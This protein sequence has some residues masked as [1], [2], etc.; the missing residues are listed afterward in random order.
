[1]L[2]F[3]RALIFGSLL[4]LWFIISYIIF[5]V[6]GVG[7]ISIDPKKPAEDV[8]ASLADDTSSNFAK[9]LSRIWSVSPSI[10]GTID[11]VERGSDGRLRLAGWAID[12]TKA[13][14]LS[15]FLIIP[16]KAVLLTHTG[17]KRDDVS[18]AL[19]LSKDFDLAGFDNVFPFE[20]DCKD[21]DLNP[22]IVAVNQTKEFSLIT[23][24]VKVA[25]CG[26]AKKPTISVGN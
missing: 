24:A 17:T 12:K 19:Q 25:G 13:A 26:K 21:M 9:R 4:A 15:I 1:M 14:P 11:T 5:D 16:T 23:T 20:F 22:F 3:L 2:V 18:S 8:V 7:S 10:T 6:V